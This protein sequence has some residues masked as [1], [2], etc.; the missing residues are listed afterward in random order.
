[1]K[2]MLLILSLVT[3]KVTDSETKEPITGARIEVLGEN[4]VYY[5]GIE[6]EFKINNLADT[7]KLRV[8]FMTYKDTIISVGD[9]KNGIV[10]LDSYNF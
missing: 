6:G 4:T 2:I 8:S 7:T 1:M 3:G 10:Y 5:T 9:L